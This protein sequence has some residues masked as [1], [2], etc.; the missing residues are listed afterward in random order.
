MP[1]VLVGD[2]ALCSCIRQLIT[3]YTNMRSHLP[4]VSYK[5]L[6]D[7]GNNLLHDGMQ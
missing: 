6:C 4:D 3:P 7:P 2:D 5:A 1:W